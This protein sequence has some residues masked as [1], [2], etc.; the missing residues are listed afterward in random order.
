[1]ISLGNL[2]KS[3]DDIGNYWVVNQILSKELHNI[4]DECMTFTMNLMDRLEQVWLKLQVSS[5]LCS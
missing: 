1:M 3:D 2:P 4:D 5:K